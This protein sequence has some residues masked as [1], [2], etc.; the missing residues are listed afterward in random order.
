MPRVSIR[1]A[2]SSCTH[3]QE[4]QETEARLAAVRTRLHGAF[5]EHQPPNEHHRRPNT[6]RRNNTNHHANPLTPLE[7]EILLIQVL[8]SFGLLDGCRIAHDIDRLQR[9]ICPSGVN[10]F[11]VIHALVPGSRLEE[12]GLINVSES[13]RPLDADLALSDKFLYLISDNP[14]PPLCEFELQDQ[15][16]DYICRI[17]SAART[18]QPSRIYSSKS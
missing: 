5:A 14:K 15:A 16:H 13:E 8:V 12:S 7:S 4:H 1:E 3:I 2:L 11:H 9:A 6:Q 18:R 17:V 10:P